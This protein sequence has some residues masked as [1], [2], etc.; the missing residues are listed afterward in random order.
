MRYAIRLVST[1]VFPEPA[2]AIT[3]RGPSLCRV[4]ERC[5]SFKEFKLSVS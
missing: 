4:G 3:I 5:A 2:P 1:R